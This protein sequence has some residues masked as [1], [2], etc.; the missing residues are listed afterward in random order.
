MQLKWLYSRHFRNLA[1][2]TS[3]F[4]PRVNCFIGKN[5]QGKSSLLEA[6]WIASRGSSFRTQQLSDIPNYS[7][8]GFFL[9]CGFERDNLDYELSLSF[10]AAGRR[11][12][13]NRRSYDSHSQLMS[14]PV[15][16]VLPPHIQNLIK[17]P[18][19]LRRHFLN[20]LLAEIDPL[21]AHHLARY[22]RALKQRNVLL[23]K[24]DTRTCPAWE[25]ELAE[26]AS[27]LVLRRRQVTKELAPYIIGFFSMLH[28][29]STPSEIELQYESR[30]PET[31]H[32]QEIADFYAREFHARRPQELLFG[33]SLAGPHRDELDLVVNGRNIR[34]LASEGEARISAIALKLAEWHLLKE[35]LS[36]SPLLLID[37]FGAY[38]DEERKAALFNEVFRFGQ[39]FITCHTDLSGPESKTFHVEEGKITPQ[40]PLCQ[41]L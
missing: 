20:S 5:G 40:V 8:D 36:I 12:T 10:G 30:A 37:D 1:E 18:P 35:R 2:G 38:F 27:Y 4:S 34:P 31:S 15:G 39:V 13:L 41:N 3:E 14:H 23:R 21:Y 28:K 22:T 11:L 25:A 29:E 19:P 16:V 7:S 26:S 9:E 24:K 32:A 17:G 6:I 33:M